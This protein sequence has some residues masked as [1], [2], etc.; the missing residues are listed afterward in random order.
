[1]TKENIE[2]FIMSKKYLK[3]I[4]ENIDYDSYIKLLD[5]DV[6]LKEDSLQKI[7]EALWEIN[8]EE[9]LSLKDILKLNR[10][11]SYKEA[12]EISQKIFGRKMGKDVYDSI[13]A[14]DK[15][16]MPI[17]KEN[18]E[19]VLEVI[20]KL[21]DLKYIDDQILIE[22]LE[23]DLPMSI[24]ALYNFK[25][26]YSL[27]ILDVNFTSSI[28]EQFVI[29]KEL[30]L[31]ELLKLLKELNLEQNQEN[32]I[33]LRE[34]LLAGVNL[35]RES[36]ESLLNMKSTLKEL[37]SLMNEEN[38]VRLMEEGIDPLREDI[39]RLVDRLNDKSDFKPNMP[40]GDGRAI[41]KEIEY[42]KNITSKELANLIQKGEDFNIENLK[43]IMETN[44]NIREGISGKAVQKAITLS[45]IFGTLGELDSNTIA[46]AARRYSTIS[47]DNLYNSQLELNRSNR[48]VEPISKAE[49][50]L[51]RQ[52]YFHARNNT[53]FNLVRDSIK[54]A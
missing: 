45:N 5:R 34:L 10:G 17:N 33:L 3:E 9:D 15:A 39:Y 42:I 13:I 43:R 11:L 40:I 41:L 44:P 28:Y 31:E 29:E 47:L 54:R 14:L 30:S 48:S 8:K 19:K 26:S 1:M 36:F 52:D 4:I 6:N 24:E 22:F 49:E 7:A 37:V 27:G 32:L 25:H 50:N 16:N 35:T 53:T 2:S 38:V 46:L 18:I 20:D 23:E 51:I 21:Q 12:E